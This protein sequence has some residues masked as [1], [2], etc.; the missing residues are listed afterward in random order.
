MDKIWSDESGIKNVPREQCLYCS[1][2]NTDAKRGDHDVTI[3]CHECGK[4]TST[5]IH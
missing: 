4:E 1:S 5:S 3:K 2:V